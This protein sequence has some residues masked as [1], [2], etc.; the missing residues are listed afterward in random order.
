M[1]FD[2]AD[3]AAGACWL[4]VN[5]LLGYSAW[6]WACRFFPEDGPL[7]KVGHV[8][9]LG[10]SGIVAVATTLGL[11]GLLGG[12][13]LLLGVSGA[14]LAALAVLRRLAPSHPVQPPGRSRSETLW[15]WMWAT[16][17][18]LGAGHVVVAGLLMY[19][20]DWDS[21]AYHLPMVDHWLRDGSLYTPDC[22][23]WS[24]PG[25]G[26]LLAL[27]AVAPFSGDFLAALNNMPTSILLA[28]ASIAL[29][30]RFGLPPTITHLAALAVVCNHVV[31]TQ[32]VDT[33]ND[34]AATAAFLAA[35]SYALRHAEKP[36]RDGL[37]LGALSLGLLAGVKF[38]AV[39]YAA[40]ALA[41]WT[42]LALTAQ[43][44]SASLRVILAGG[45]GCLALGGY[46]Y[47]R[48]LVVTGSPLY[49][50]DFFRHPDVLALL[51]PDVGHTSFLGNGRPELFGMYL[52]SIWEMTGPCQLA[53]FALAPLSLSWLVA[54]GTWYLRRGRGEEGRSRLAL[55]A[56]L[57]GGGLLL[58][59]TPFA[60][61]DD[62]GTLNQLRWH[63]CPVRYGLSLLGA[64]I[65]AA[66][67]LLGDV[68][69]WL[70]R[71]VG[72]WSLTLL[73]APAAAVFF[74]AYHMARRQ[75]PGG[76]DGLLVGANLALACLAVA[77]A[78]REWPGLRRWLVV[79]VMAVA[80]PAWGWACGRLSEDWHC[81]FAAHYDQTLGGDQFAYLERGLPGGAAVYV[82]E[83][84]Y[85]PYFGSRRQFRACQ[86]VYAFSPEWIEEQLLETGAEFVAV[87][88]RQ[89]PAGW[90]NFRGFEEC[91][92][93]YPT[94]FRRV[95][96]GGG[97]AVFRVIKPTEDD[98]KK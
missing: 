89:S 54:S 90:N 17:A 29:G 57:V 10:W 97:I 43:G 82:L 93:R 98:P 32:L 94:R 60:V 79:G 44:R 53:G 2:H 55:A 92:A 41:V 71:R 63:Y 81:G 11:A 26:E 51:Y 34:V 84:R 86:P 45:A 20:A 40:L 69:A 35:L 59:V 74:Q 31:L 25:N 75:G 22:G 24:N 61:E 30:R 6:A 68:L 38:Y 67:V 78:A 64:G 66:A 19:P 4:V 70:Q 21:L 52:Q 88:L 39:G 7:E 42:C 72:L 15:L 83:H 37:L 18:S 8:I 80:V 56:T 46:W 49:P 16:L 36:S 12:P 91:L 27:W 14:C 73:F 33:E 77:L 58:A 85:Y 87:K 96:E 28:C 5:V 23:R 95:T 1:S 50:R 48:N 76:V 9:V 62:P 3:A 47:F 65:L 13:A